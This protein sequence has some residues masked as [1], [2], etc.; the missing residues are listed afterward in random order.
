MSPAAY[1]SHVRLSTILA[2]RAVD[3]HNKRPCNYSQ[4]SYKPG[5]FSDDSSISV[6]SNHAIHK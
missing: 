4:D 1:M 5:G 6:L 3:P 2:L